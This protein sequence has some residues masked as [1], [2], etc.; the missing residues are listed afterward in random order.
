MAAQPAQAGLSRRIWLAVA[1]VLAAA[2]V[3]FLGGVD[4]YLFED[5]SP[6]AHVAY[7]AAPFLDLSFTLIYVTALAIAGG[8]AVLLARLALVVSGSAHPRVGDLIVLPLVA[9]G[10]PVAFWGIALR[11]PGVFLALVLMLAGGVALMLL[12]TYLAT[13]RMTRRSVARPIAA[14]LG[15]CAGLLTLLLLYGGL[16]LTHLLVMRAAVPNLYATT[17]LGGS[18]VSELAIAIGLMALVTCLAGFQVA[19]SSLSIAPVA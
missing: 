5:G 6:L 10:T 14:V 12:V 19:R 1:G 4:V 17:L 16:A 7:Q 11:Q 8:A 15:A 3:A 2:L 18:S 9:F 13:I